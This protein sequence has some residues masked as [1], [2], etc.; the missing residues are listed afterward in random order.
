MMSELV[1]WLSRVFSILTVWNQ[2]LTCVSLQK[3]VVFEWGLLEP[4]EVSEIWSL[5]QRFRAPL[6][7]E[8]GWYTWTPE[9]CWEVPPDSLSCYNK[10]LRVTWW[11]RNDFWYIRKLRERENNGKKSHSK[12][13]EDTNIFTFHSPCGIWDTKSDSASSTLIS[14]ALDH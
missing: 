2:D 13:V 12:E 14:L 4:E 3:R 7:G 9:L 1:I 11:Q 10:E 6:S 8:N 5:A